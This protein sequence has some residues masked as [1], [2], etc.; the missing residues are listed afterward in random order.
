MNLPLNI[1]LQQIL[2]HLLN[3]LL[4]FAALYFILYK[5]VKKFMNK[6]ADYY[7][8]LGEQADAKI[9]EAEKIKTDYEAKYAAMTEDI[10][11]E[12]L[13][14]EKELDAI[15]IQQLETARKEAASIVERAH[16][17][18]EADRDRIMSSVQDNVWN[19]VTT[20]AKGVFLNSTSEAYDEFLKATE[21]SDE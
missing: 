7:K 1:D 4:L 16:T 11:N 21:E 13:A 20:A 5:P 8:N 10:A 2:I 3:S 19:L 12:R 18:A 14:A 17:K 6:R 15:R 9:A